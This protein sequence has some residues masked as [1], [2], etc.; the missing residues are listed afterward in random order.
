[1]KKVIL[2]T[3]VKLVDDE[4]VRVLDETKLVEEVSKAYEVKKF[5]IAAHSGLTFETMNGE[6]VR[7]AK[8]IKITSDVPLKLSHT[9]MANNYNVGFYVKEITLFGV[10]DTGFGDGST[11]VYTEGDTI[12]YSGH[13]ALTNIQKQPANVKVIWYY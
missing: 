1:M 7:G 10:Q 5:I 9:H 6:G 2:E 8:G 4:V 11:S 3:K 13:I 12:G